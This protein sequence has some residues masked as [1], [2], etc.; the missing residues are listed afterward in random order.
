MADSKCFDEAGSAGHIVGHGVVALRGA[1]RL[2]A[3]TA[4]TL[5]LCVV[6]AASYELRA[7]GAWRWIQQDWLFSIYVRRVGVDSKRIR[8]GGVGRARRVVGTRCGVI[9]VDDTVEMVGSNHA[10]AEVGGGYELSRLPFGL[11]KHYAIVAQMIVKV[12]ELE[13]WDEL[14]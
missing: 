1:L 3:R 10:S 14:V 11:L 2:R 9:L 13:A 8:S 6:Q 5:L 12:L 4:G 7:R